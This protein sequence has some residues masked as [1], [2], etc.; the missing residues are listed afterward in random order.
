MG[1][2]GRYIADS[3]RGYDIVGLQE[4]WVYDDYLRIK[5]LVQDTLPY[6]K[7]WHS[8]VLG[9]GLIIFS[10]FPIVSTMMRRFA[11]NGDPFKF[12]HGDWYVGKC[13]VSATVVHPTCGEIEVFNTHVSILQKRKDKKTQ[14][15]H[16]L[17]PSCAPWDPLP[18]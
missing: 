3:S 8:G 13:C 12:Y 6:S 14:L 5:D 10:K 2:I 18:C 16:G 9:S 11:L 4:I 7:H 1:A 17:I 15:R